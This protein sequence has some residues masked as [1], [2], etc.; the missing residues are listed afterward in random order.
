MSELEELRL[1]IAKA[2]GWK[3]EFG[4]MDKA[5]SKDHEFFIKPDGTLSMYPPDWPRDIAAAWELVG[6][7]TQVQVRIEWEL[8]ENG[9]PCWRCL[10]CN[11]AKNYWTIYTGTTAPEAI[12]HAWLE[13]KKAQP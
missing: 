2:K 8:D 9:T 12:C 10:T 13:W 5:S 7:L 4:K 11:E 3:S 6:D 1:Q